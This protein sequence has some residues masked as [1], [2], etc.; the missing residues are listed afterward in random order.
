MII[1]IKCF[2]CGQVL[3]DKHDYFIHEARR[4]KCHRDAVSRRTEELATLMEG[5]PTGEGNREKNSPDKESEPRP[6]QKGGSDHPAEEF[7]VEYLTHERGVEKTIEGILLD[8]L[9][10]FRPCCR[11]IM[12]SHVD[13]GF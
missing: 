4:R 1:P 10:L 6:Q 5:T 13:I 2:G 7:P 11:S 8:E 12:L 9:M 3:A